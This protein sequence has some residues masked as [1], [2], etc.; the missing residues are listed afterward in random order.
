MRWNSASSR[1]NS[2]PLPFVAVRFGNV[3]GSDGSILP[4]FQR[5][6]A[7]GGPVTVTD[8]KV[9]RYFMLP[10]EAAQL[11]IQAGAMGRGG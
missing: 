10:S 3:L 8:A 4:L 5:Q 2:G 11:V 9:S 6:I 1:F 7:K